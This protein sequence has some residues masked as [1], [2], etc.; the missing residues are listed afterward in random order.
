[1]NRRGGKRKDSGRK[2]DE[3]KSPVC[4]RMTEDMKDKARRIGGGSYSDGIRIA[5]CAYKE[6][7]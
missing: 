6:E 3:P 7:R 4:S 1:M 2:T 5:L